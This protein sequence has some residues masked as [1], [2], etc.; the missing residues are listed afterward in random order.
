LAKEVWIRFHGK[1]EEFKQFVKKTRGLVDYYLVEDE[2]LASDAKSMNVKTVSETLGD[3]KLVS[4]LEDVSSNSCL[5]LEV[6]SRGDE[7][8]AVEAA[9]MGCKYVLVRCSD[10]KIIPLE[11]LVAKLHG[12]TKII[13]EATDIEE[14]ETLLKILELGVDGVLME[15][16]DPDDVKKL[17]KSVDKIALKTKAVE[18]RRAKVVSIR[19]LKLGARVCLDTCDMLNPCEGFLVG[20]QSAGL[21]LIEAE[22]HG[23]PYVEAR[24]FRVNAGPPAL[25]ILAPGG[26]TRYLS[27]LRAGETLL[28]VK[29]DGTFR[30]VELCRVK[31]EWRPLKLIEAE[32]E[33]KTYKVVVQ[34]AET[35][36]FVTPNGSKSLAELSPGDELLIFIQEGGGRHFGTLV[37][38][39][40][41][42]ER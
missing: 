40:R 20:C 16:D 1:P 34:D 35:I 38:G 9:D 8:K 10:W 19:P 24:P 23:N 36:R 26:K 14:A 12:R 28:A 3:L 11:N 6:K 7:V 32:Y 21:F 29:G 13:A 4:R 31:I 5:K 15:T 33:G 18:L 37:K 22:V 42:I 2:R 30:E 17:R 41:I 27:E 39:E 25:Y